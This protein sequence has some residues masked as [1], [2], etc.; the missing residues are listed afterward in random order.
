MDLLIGTM[1]LLSLIPTGYYFYH[2]AAPYAPTSDERIRNVMVLAG[3]VRGKKVADLGAGDGR[4]MLEFARRGAYVDGF[5]IN[6]LLVLR[7]KRNIHRA[8][9]QDRAHVYWRSFWSKDL[10]QYD[11]IFLYCIIYM[12]KRIEYKLTEELKKGKRGISVYSIFPSWQSV[13]KAGDVRL[14]RM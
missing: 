6:P 14:Y 13:Q 4:V 9:L 5:E 10:N 8:G 7:A 3:D 12:M 2:F 11:V 1:F